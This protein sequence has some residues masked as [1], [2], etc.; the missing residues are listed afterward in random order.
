LNLDIAST[1]ITLLNPQTN[2]NNDYIWLYNGTVVHQLSDILEFNAK[3][4][5]TFITGIGDKLHLIPKN[6]PIDVIRLYLNSMSKQTVTETP[7][8]DDSL[9]STFSVSCY[10]LANNLYY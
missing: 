4:K 9:S 10:I 7:T 1:F 6:T 8:S 5:A 2:E 3:G